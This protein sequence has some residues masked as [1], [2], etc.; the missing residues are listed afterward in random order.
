MTSEEAEKYFKTSSKSTINRLTK[1]KLAAIVRYEVQPRSGVDYTTMKVPQLRELIHQEVCLSVAP[2][3]RDS[4][5]YFS[6]LNLA[7]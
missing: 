7:F 4:L 5:N 1:A 6:G 3:N 2:F